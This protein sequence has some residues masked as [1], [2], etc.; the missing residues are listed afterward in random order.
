MM[1]LRVCISC[2]TYYDYCQAHVL[3]RHICIRTG[4]CLLV[5]TVISS[6]TEKFHFK[7]SSRC[8][9]IATTIDVVSRSEFL[10]YLF[11]MLL[12]FSVEISSIFQC[13]SPAL[14]ILTYIQV[15]VEVPLPFRRA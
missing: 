15:P 2:S 4:H 6:D 8:D 5:G 9:L 11:R 13:D 7:V 1:Y 10:R 12:C 3:Y 14:V